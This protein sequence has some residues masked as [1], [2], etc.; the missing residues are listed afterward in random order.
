LNQLFLTRT[1][2]GDN[3]EEV[4][5]ALRGTIQNPQ[6]IGTALDGCQIVLRQAGTQGTGTITSTPTNLPTAVQEKRPQTTVHESKSALSNGAKAGIT[7][8]VVISVLTSIALGAYVF[9]KKKKRTNPPVDNHANPPINE[10]GQDTVMLDGASVFEADSKS[11]FQAELPETS[12]PPIAELSP[13]YE[14][15]ELQG[16]TEYNT[17]RHK[18]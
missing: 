16:D 7:T 12:E 14:I 10:E 1:A 17:T 11:V 4:C 8:A 3:P 15:L 2:K 13:A 9:I 5:S 6:T 18:C